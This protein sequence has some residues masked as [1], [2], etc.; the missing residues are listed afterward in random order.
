MFLTRITPLV[1]A[2]A[3][4]LSQGCSSKSPTAAEAKPDFGKLS[5]TPKSGAGLDGVFHLVLEKKPGVKPP[6]LLGLLIND[7]ENGEH[8]CYVYQNLP[9]DSTT[10]VNDSG[11]G[12]IPLEAKSIGNQ[13][14]EVLQEGTSISTA[15]PS[16]ISVDLH[17]R[18]R[19]A[20]KGEK[21]L[22][23]IALDS[24]NQGTD[25]EPLGLWK[26]E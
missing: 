12:V 9:A 22:Y 26:V 24:Q 6:L 8:A 14:C 3:C 1:L 16:Q 2:V 11:L 19:P 13:Q 15:N 7:R 23:G 21:H 17:L 18:F 4:F 5:V 10:L 25:L 20:F